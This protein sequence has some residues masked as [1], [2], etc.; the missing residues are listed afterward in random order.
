[1]GAARRSD[2]GTSAGG[3]ASGGHRRASGPTMAALRNI[4]ALAQARAH[5]DAGSP[6]GEKICDADVA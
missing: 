2:A 5:W 4:S 6:A 1:M 3:A